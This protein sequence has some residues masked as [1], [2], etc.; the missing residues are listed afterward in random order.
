MPCIA[1]MVFLFLVKSGYLGD[2]QMQAF[3]Q[4]QAG[5]RPQGGRD[6]V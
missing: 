6:L 5:A 4:A 2:E 3:N 1:G